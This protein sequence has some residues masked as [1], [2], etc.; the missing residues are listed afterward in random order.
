MTL[1]DR[2]GVTLLL[3]IPIGTLAI[4][5]WSNSLFLLAVIV[6]IIIL[7]QRRTLSLK[8]S[9]WALILVITFSAPFLIDLLMQGLRGEI[10]PAQ[11][12]APSRLLLGAPIL[13]FCLNKKIPDLRLLTLV[14]G[15]SVV[16][17]LVSILLD[18]RGVNFWGRW[19]TSSA[20]PNSLGCMTAIFT[21]ALLYLCLTHFT[22][23]DWLACGFAFLTLLLGIFILLKSQSRGGWI[24]FVFLVTLVL[25]LT[26]KQ[27]LRGVGWIIV[28]IIALTIYIA[29]L[30]DNILKRIGS[31][32]LEYID[33]LKSPQDA[34][35]SI[36]IR[37]NMVEVSWALI[38]HSP[39]L[40][41]G[42]H[43]Y[44]GILSFSGFA[45][46]PPAALIDIVNTPHNEILNKTLRSGVFGGLVALLVFLAPL[47]FFIKVLLHS[48][49][50]VYK[51]YSS[52]GLIL[53]VGFFISGMSS[54]ILGLSYLSSF[55]SAA[56]LGLAGLTMS[57]DNSPK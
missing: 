4:K 53:V 32:Y 31:I 45:H 12:D 27:G 44:A 22:S 40:G 30:D 10:A 21:G 29:L 18:P 15:L 3:L 42:D 13:L 25:I 19:A 7:V 26:K 55:Y 41:Y 51:T 35:T 16:A 39:I 9:P 56:A 11:L 24:V 38:K 54:G 6:S 46:L 34:T 14:V 17:T 5:K 52:V 47:I 33:W 2:L 43:G 20:D 23:R 49:S 57:T 36:G 1:I 8:R 28:S 50:S 48:T 37:L